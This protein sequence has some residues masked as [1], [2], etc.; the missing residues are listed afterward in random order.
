MSM[1]SFN[2][3]YF[4]LILFAFSSCQREDEKTHETY[5]LSDIRP[6]FFENLNYDSPAVVQNIP[7][8]LQN[9]TEVYNKLETQYKK[10][11]FTSEQDKDKMR[12]IGMYYSFYLLSLTGNYLDGNLKSLDIIGDREV[13]LFSNLRKNEPN[14]HQIEL[15]KMMDRAVEVS[16]FSSNVNG[17]NDKAFGFSVAVRQVRDRLKDPNHFNSR[18]TQDLAIDYVGHRLVNYEIIS[19]WNVLMSM[20]T[21][22]NY[23]DPLNTFDNK[24]MDEILFHVNARLV[25]GTLPDLGGK[26]PEILGPIFRFDINLKKIDW[27]LKKKTLS[28]E[29]IETL[30]KSLNVLQTASDFV[31]NE[32]TALLN[33]WPYRNT[34]D[35]RVNKM[36]EILDYRSKISGAKPELTEFINS[37]EFKKAY[38]CYSCHKSSGL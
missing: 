31:K 12:L 16:T 25:P 29:D 11:D 36:R 23:Q 32:K 33:S 17:F 10:G 7:S 4:F 9:F 30:D 37:K 18:S 6:N 27:L 13:G 34:F 35:E 24:R 38:Q 21:M 1:K 2:L 28:K 22:T 19:N 26:Y 5:F 15:E 14:F 8:Y 3:T 20:V